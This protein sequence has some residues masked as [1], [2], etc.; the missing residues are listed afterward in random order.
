M[1]RTTLFF[2]AMMAIMISIPFSGFSQSDDL[3]DDGSVWNLT[4]VRL[5]PNLDDEYL[6]GLN[7]TWKSTMDEMKKENIIKSYKILKGNA[8]NQEDFNL[9]LMIEFD[10]YA[11]MDPDPA[12]QAK[13]DEI[14]KRVRDAMGDE[15]KKTVASYST[16]RDI[17]GSKIMREIYLK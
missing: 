16:M 17:F 4:F 10:N 2:A 11:A 3:Y 1:K 15:F 5:H 13:M 14:E 9:L 8:A 6:K 7:K 12:R